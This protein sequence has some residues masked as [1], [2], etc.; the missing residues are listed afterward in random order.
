MPDQPPLQ[1]SGPPA[2]LDSCADAVRG[3]YDEFMTS[4]MVRY[5]LYGNRRLDA[6]GARILPFLTPRARI[7]DV[8]CGIGI[9][10]ERVGRRVSRGFV[11]GI[12]ISPRN[13]WYAKQTVKRPNV[14]FETVDLRIDPHR[15]PQLLGGLADVV[16]LIDVIEHIPASERQSLLGTLRSLSAERSTLVVTYPSPQFHEYL[17]SH[18][19]AELQVI[20]NVIDLATL[21]QEA[22]GAGFH[23]IQ[24]SLEAVWMANQYCHAIFQTDVSISPPVMTNG[25][26]WI[27]KA[28][29]RALCRGASRVL[30]S[31]RRRK[32]VTRVFSSRSEN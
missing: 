30:A 28:I 32:Y 8:G 3:Y 21:I 24:Y 29:A 18:D 22:A 23:L 16:L 14:A 19:P 31:A 17:S 25:Q 7:L 1:E 9:I 11:L 4:R 10:A 6:A 2:T 15:V 27:H 20:D 12:D 5:R 26:G 13:I